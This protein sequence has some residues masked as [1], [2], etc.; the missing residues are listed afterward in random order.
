MLNDCH[1]SFF[2]SSSTSGMLCE[3]HLSSS[4]IP[5]FFTSCTTFVRE[6]RWPYLYSVL[7]YN[8]QRFIDSTHV[9]RGKLFTPN[10]PALLFLSYGLADIV[11]ERVQFLCGS[12][13]EEL[14]QILIYRIDQR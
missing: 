9:L 5:L 6:I 8:L 11:M 10:L 4:K 3:T 12:L 13:E 14:H 2:I 1:L 7:T